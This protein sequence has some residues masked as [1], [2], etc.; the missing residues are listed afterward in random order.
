MNTEVAV[1]T[2]LSMQDFMEISSASQFLPRIQ[3]FGS[4]N[5]VVKQGTFPAGHY[6]LSTAKDTIE[7]LGKEFN[8][9]PYK[10]RAKAVDFRD[11][12]NIVQV[13]DKNSEAFADIKERSKVKDSDCMY[14]PEFLVWLPDQE[15]F[16][17]FFFNNPTMRNAAPHLY[18]FT[19]EGNV[20]KQAAPATCKIRFIP[21]PKF[22]GWHGPT[23]V[24]CSV[25]M[26][27]PPADR[28]EQEV[29]LFMNPPVKAPAEEVE[30][31]TSGREE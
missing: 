5:A 9:I 20:S 10:V 27:S 16:A 2:D 14:G 13:F 15:R 23:I 19:P 17:T 31:E 11:R 7:N 18:A 26:E 12:K 22:G 1:V 6:G 29:A 28:I 24:K 30:A 25:P 21:D 4:N 8:C 3:L